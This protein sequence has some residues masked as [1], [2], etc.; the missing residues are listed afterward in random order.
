MVKKSR[1]KKWCKVL[2]SAVNKNARYFRRRAPLWAV[3][4]SYY[5]RC[6]SFFKNRMALENKSVFHVSCNPLSD[7]VTR[8]SVE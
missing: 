4:K 8:N 6:C 2:V 1:K 7:L 3:V 5:N